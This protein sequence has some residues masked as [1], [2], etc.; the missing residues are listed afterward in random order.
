MTSI[1]GI[2]AEEPGL[3]PEFSDE[4]L[5][6]DFAE[7]HADEL[8]Y[9]AVWGHW[10]VWSGL[11]WRTDQTLTALK[12]A[13]FVCRETAARANASPRQ[14]E[15]AS[16]KKSGAI[17]TLARADHR[18]AATVDQW[19]TNLWA[20]NTPGGVV[21][22]RTGGHRPAQ[23][24]DHVTKITTVAPGGDCPMWLAFLRR[25]T[26]E[27]EELQYYLQRVAGYCL[28]GETAEHAL[29]FLHGLG[30]NGKSVFIST[31]AGLL[32]D[33]HR[34]AAVETFTATRTERHPTELAMLRG[35]RLV[36]AVETEE[37]GRWAESKIK[38]LTGGDKV[39]ARF[40][41][42][43]FFEYIPQFKLMIAGNHRPGLR[44]VDEAIRRRF[45]LIPF[46]V[47]IPP[48]ERDLQLVD[49]LRAEWPGILSW[50]IA[51]CHA[52]QDGGLAPPEAVR[53]ATDEYLEAEDKVGLWLKAC[54][55]IDNSAQTPVGALWQAWR[56][57]AQGAGEYV[58]SNRVFSQKLAERGFAPHRGDDRGFRGLRLKPN[59]GDNVPM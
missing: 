1:L 15:L 57:W 58:G 35:A 3:A 37:G 36:T 38:S 7:R 43:D 33:Y 56:D 30:A 13:R 41:R 29:F 23:P 32:G 25:I 48:E 21:D 28:T 47:I 34:T 51:G 24:A 40:M 42:Q 12:K 53:D 55:E 39:T 44:S 20:L 11:Y 27:D 46:E 5:A 45:H 6:L 8:R 59:Y 10:M 26:A 54:C 49:K 17:L 50:A 22:L 18:L 4:A 52:W 19:D 14:R 31:L 9:V 2:E 16:A